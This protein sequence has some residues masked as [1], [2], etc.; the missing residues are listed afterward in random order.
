MKEDICRAAR[1]KGGSE[2]ET[3]G[4]G[5]YMGQMLERR[6]IFSKL[7]SYGPNTSSGNQ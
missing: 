2:A 7:V 1:R 4:H 6:G 5:R 3:R